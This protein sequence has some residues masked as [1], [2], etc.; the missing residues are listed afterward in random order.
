[1]SRRGG[2]TQIGGTGERRRPGSRGEDRGPGF[3]AVV[4]LALGSLGGALPCEAQERNLDQVDYAMYFMSRVKDAPECAMSVKD[5]R[6]AF[7][8]PVTNPAMT[9]P[10][11]FSWHLFTQ[12]VRD[13]FW[14]R[15]PDERQ[16]WP[17]EP[18]RLCGPGESPPG[19]CEPGSRENDPV[20][21]PLF[22]GGD[23]PAALRLRTEPRPLRRSIRAH[24]FGPHERA[25]E[26]RRLIEMLGLAE[27]PGAAARQKMRRCAALP[28]PD[29]PESIGRVIRQTNG[30]L[31]VR[32]EAFHDYLFRN[33]LYNADGVIGV[34]E[35]N[36]RNLLANAPYRRVSYPAGGARRTTDLATI[37]F[38]ADAVMIKANWLNADLMEA[39]GAKY[40]CSSQDPSH[41]YVQKEMVQV[42]EDREGNQYD[43]SGTHRLL[44]FHVSSKDIPNWVWA[45]FE[46]VRL[47][48]RCDFTGC[49]DSWGYWSSD[50]PI[51]GTARNFVAPKVK[52]DEFPAG[53]DS[54]VYD[55][56][57]VYASETIQPQ[58]QAIFDALRIGV[59][60]AAGAE[61]TPRDAAWRSY[62]L[63]GSQVEFV[64]STGRSTYL[65]HSVTEAGFVNGSSCITCHARAG[66]DAY[67]PFHPPD[68]KGLDHPVFPLSVFTNDLSDFGY[69]RSAHGIPDKAWYHESN[70]P[71]S[72]EVLQT[73]FVW[74][75]LFARKIAHAEAR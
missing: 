46:H 64:D 27:V 9:C 37:D 20:H 69:G 32:N 49:N 4:A 75:F 54:V 55:R 71:P 51:P 11:M 25:G 59:D 39:I 67:G 70:Q 61:P 48:G 74:G 41:P 72:L 36:A 65:G 24:L 28:L 13:G 22:P 34:F 14:S 5:G 38:P 43:C 63:K 42:L 3:A 19:C 60:R 15:W 21:C 18:F 26:K 47:P 57:R 7:S 2:S 8:P 68:A 23:A 29:D 17:A 12:V 35:T 6:I 44:A 50:P 56:D 73:D 30:E 31:T 45:T 33:N 1:M 10:D 52:D 53:A 16:N 40:G 58:L 62:R 66:T